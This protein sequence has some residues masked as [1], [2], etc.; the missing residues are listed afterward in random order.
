MNDTKEKRIK[1][2]VIVTLLIVALISTVPVMV[3]ACTFGDIKINEIMYNP[4]TEQGSDANMEWI[5]LCNNDTDAINI[6]NWTIDGTPIST[7][8][9][10]LQPGDCVILA[11]NKTAFDA[12]YGALPY[13]V[14]AASFL[15]T[16]DPGDTIV[17]RNCTGAE[18]DNVTYNASW[19]ADG[20]GKTLERTALGWAESLVDGG[21][22]CE[23]NSVTIVIPFSPW[24]PPMINIWNIT[25]DAVNPENV[26]KNATIELFTSTELIDNETYYVITIN[27]PIGSTKLYV[28]KDAVN[29]DDLRKRVVTMMEPGIEVVN[30]TFDPAFV[31]WD[32]PLWYGKTWNGTTNVTGMLVNETGSVISINSTAVVSGKITA[33]VVTVPLG[34]FP[35]LVL[36]TIISHEVAGQPTTNLEKSWISP[37]DNGYLT[38]KY[39]TYRNGNLMEEFELIEIIPPTFL[40]AADNGTAIEVTKGQFTVITLEANP[41]TGYTWEV[42][43][44]LDEQVLRQVG[45]IAFV[46]ESELLGAPGVQIVTFGAVGAGE[47][48]IKLVYHRPWETDVEP[49]DTFTVPVTVS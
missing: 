11:R 39:Q 26:G 45:E 14:I 48:T 37:M 4:S 28:G 40:T 30:L 31:N 3:S 17:L 2:T 6:C 19:G 36:E 24:V 34:T 41:T 22:P 43:E 23:L 1:T 49:L 5:E 35:C 18:M 29:E 13:T 10:V 15:L 44:P 33:D 46:P 27:K 25:V 9:L 47:A 42:T 21:T 8:D 20:N 7:V 12:Y 38:P 16:N 32:F